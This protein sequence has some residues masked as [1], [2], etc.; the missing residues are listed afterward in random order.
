MR[1]RRPGLARLALALALALG[2]VVAVAGAGCGG[3]DGP[4]TSVKVGD[5]EV[6]ATR[7]ADALQGV[8][9]ARAQAA[10][11]DVEA[12]ERTFLDRSHD[13]LHVL[14]LALEAVDRAKAGELL[15]AKQLVE[16]DLEA[17][18]VRDGLAKD[19]GRL[20]EVTRSGLARLEI[21]T[22]PCE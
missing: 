21:S 4:P 5:E 20:G 15:L 8:C 11:G 1:A 3:D 2:L 18:P 6:P 19:L 12:A 17:T 16:S 13:T 14:A 7:L 9:V 22:P 10:A